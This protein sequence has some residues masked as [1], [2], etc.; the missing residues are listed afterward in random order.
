MNDKE[1]LDRVVLG[2][3]VYCEN[4]TQDERRAEEVHQFVEWLHAQYGY[5][6]NKTPPSVQHKSQ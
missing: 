1:W 4:R 3:R 6:Y 5:V 2:A